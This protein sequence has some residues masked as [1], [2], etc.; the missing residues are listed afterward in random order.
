MNLPDTYNWD[1]Y[2]MLDEGTD[3]ARQVQA[4]ARA[5]RLARTLDEMMEAMV[6]AE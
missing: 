5:M 6:E 1:D 4:V 2:D 3:E